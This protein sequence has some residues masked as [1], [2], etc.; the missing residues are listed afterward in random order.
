MFALAGDPHARSF[1]DPGGNPDVDGPCAAIVRDRE[2]PGRALQR[3]FEIQLDL[4]LHVSAL[5]RRARPRGAAPR[6]R[7]LSAAQAT[8]KERVEEVGEGIRVAEHLAHLFF[9]HRAKTAAAGP[10]AVVDV[11]ARRRTATGLSR[12]GLLVHAPVRA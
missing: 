5:S 1:A 12:A 11:P 3:V 6:P 9:G 4:L 8:A 10:A 2:S 7:L